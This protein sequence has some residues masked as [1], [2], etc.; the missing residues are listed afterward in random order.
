MVAPQGR[1]F[2]PPAIASA[3]IAARP[4]PELTLAT[5]F[6]Y[7]RNQLQ[8]FLSILSAHHRLAD[9]AIHLPNT[10]VSGGLASMAAPKRH[11]RRLRLEELKATM[12]KNHSEAYGVNLDMIGN[13][14]A[15]LTF[16]PRSVIVMVGAIRSF[17]TWLP[18]WT[19][20]KASPQRP[21][22]FVWIKR[23]PGQPPADARAAM[24]P[25]V[26][27]T[28]GPLPKNRFPTVELR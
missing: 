19:V 16:G 5:V 14:V 18:P 24:R 27:V 26:F 9:D 25:T 3:E 2:F 4:S 17:P 7:K 23:H 13:R 11:F 28:T 10:T 6:Y 8:R 21:M 1:A 15:A 20:S 12:E 22:P